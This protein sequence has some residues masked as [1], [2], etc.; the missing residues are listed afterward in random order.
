[1][2]F[3][4]PDSF[5]NEEVEKDDRQTVEDYF[6]KIQIKKPP[7]SEFSHIKAEERERDERKVKDRLEFYS[8]RNK[9]KKPYERKKE[10][11][12]KKRAVIFEKM[13]VFLQQK[14]SEDIYLSLA[15]DYEDLINNNDLFLEVD[16]EGEYAVLGIDATTI[17]DNPLEISNKIMNNLSNIKDGKFKEA[18]YFQS[19]IVDDDGEFKESK[20]Q[21]VVPLVVGISNSYVD[22][23]VEKYAQII[24]Q[25]GLKTNEGRKEAERLEKEID[26]YK[27][28]E[29]F[30]EEIIAQ[31]KMYMTYSKEKHKEVFAECQRLNE[32]FTKILQK[33]REQDKDKGRG[34]VFDKTKKFI[35]DICGRYSEDVSYRPIKSRYEEQ[36]YKESL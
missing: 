6:E 3:E 21:K 22:D 18:K 11:E 30:F 35:I 5:L 36:R 33:R 28:Y 27:L 13:L 15:S 20:R 9:E 4:T 10:L 32:L 14:V 12:N 16:F 7:L 23:V 1:M 25:R 34:V 2:R 8:K 24:Y 29:I 19:E 26:D 17:A 31:L